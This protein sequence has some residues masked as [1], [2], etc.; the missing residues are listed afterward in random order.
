M[1]AISRRYKY[2]SPPSIGLLLAT[3]LKVFK[4]SDNSETGKKIPIWGKNPHC[5]SWNTK[6]AAWTNEQCQR[7]SGTRGRLA[8]CPIHTRSGPVPQF[9]VRAARGNERFGPVLDRTGRPDA[10]VNQPSRSPPRSRP[11][12]LTASQGA[13]PG[14][15]CLWQ[16]FRLQK[17]SGL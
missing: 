7:G 11:H 10:S 2:I 8:R 15:Y 3:P 16:R 1:F 4:H 14:S 9:H 6:Y 17:C 5:C 13:G 12:R